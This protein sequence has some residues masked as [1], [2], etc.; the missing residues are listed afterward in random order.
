MEFPSEKS[1]VSLPPYRIEPPDVLQVELLKP[2][3]GA[4]VLNGRY[5][6]RPDGTIDLRQYGVVHTAGKTII[7]AR[8]ALQKHLAKYFD[9]PDVSVEV[10]AFNSKVYYV[11]MQGPVLGDNVR[12]L[13]I[14][15]N[16]TVL[17]AIAQ[18]NGLSQV[19]GM[20]IWI[21]RPASN[22]SSKQQILPI[23]W[24]EIA[25]GRRCR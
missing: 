6:V 25:R 13:P 23:D 14:T 8:I 1:K 7:A 11:I 16:E 24:D 2:A 5:L 3:S 4:A 18:I 10:A 12:R 21:A 9:S 17:D 19:S 22:S 20:K 15:G